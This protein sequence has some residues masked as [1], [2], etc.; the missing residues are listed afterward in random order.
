MVQEHMAAD[1]EQA[2]SA[3]LAH[4]DIICT[5]WCD[6]LGYGAGTPG[7]D[8]IVG[9]ANASVIA[10]ASFLRGDDAARP[11]L[12]RHWLDLKPGREVVAEATVAMSLFPEAIR[13]ACAVVTNCPLAPDHVMEAATRF[14]ARTATAILQT[15]ELEPG[16]ARWAEISHELE[17]QRRERM[18]RL[19]VLTDISH[20]VN[21]TTSLDHLFEQVHAFCNRVMP[22]DN[23]M[24]ALYDAKTAQL[25]PR[26]IYHQGQRRRPLEGQQRPAGLTRLVADVREPVIFPDYLATCAE[27]GIEPDALAAS[28]GG[29]AL[30]VAP[31]IQA[32]EMIGMIGTMSPVRPNH[33]EDLELLAAVARQTAVAIENSRLIESERHRINQLTAI[34]RLA[35][36]IAMLHESDKV[37]DTAVDLIHELFG[38]DLVGVFLTDPDTKELVLRAFFTGAEQPTDIGLRLP[39][40]GPSI[41]SDVAATGQPA[42]VADVSQDPR[43]FSTPDTASTRSEIATPIRREGQVLGVLD[44][45]SLELN[46]FDRHDLTTLLTISDQLAIALENARL[47]HE[48]RERARALSL[49][50]A[51]TRAAGSSLVLDEVLERLATGIVDAAGGSACTIYL[52]DDDAG[53]FLPTAT[54]VN[55]DH[56][57]PFDLANLRGTALPVDGSPA[58]KRLMKGRQPVVGKGGAPRANS[59]CCLTRLI[60]SLP[61]LLVPLIVRDRVLG[62]AVVAGGREH[63]SFPEDR[64]RL[65]QGVA[66]SAAL[67]VEN[68]R[69]YAASHGLAIAEERG[70]IAQEIPD[71]LAQGLTGISLQLDLAD[72]FLPRKPE[73]A[74]QK[75]RRALELTRANLEEAR[76]SVLDLRAAQLQEVPLPD[77]LRRLA[78]RFADDGEIAV[79]VVTRGLDRRLSARLEIGL[80]RITEEA[81]DNIRRHAH[82]HSASVALAVN[83]GNVTLSIADDGVGFDPRGG[84][85]SSAGPAGGFGLVGMRER[86]RLLH[87]TL[88]LQSAPGRGTRLA[89]TVPF[90]ASQAQFE[91]K[92]RVER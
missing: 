91:S 48:E 39:A 31:M 52:L 66:D 88:D 46:A 45:Q 83:D 68:A 60:G 59:S 22:A 13:R 61:A 37:I 53:A 71:G 20:A 18:A 49:M 64:I 27:R 21:S 14:V 76:R 75:V 87:G 70:R 11:F 19:S 73:Q 58:L 89:V 79:D 90:E 24:I 36:E 7:N 63:D 86:A 62:M 32:G 74:R 40:G 51:T 78:Q 5:I 44:V 33:Q 30:L 16:A 50:L 12:T 23:F 28:M 92:L 29:M 54:V 72:A 10:F 9:L 38:Y 57:V 56:A 43:Y 15:I 25:N 82:A 41:V 55:R 34:N 1:A 26:L 2:A 81:L 80:L 42:L 6:L 77:A 8:V 35:R 65:V 84:S 47:I 17:E 69:L 3:I 4:R 85:A 67:A